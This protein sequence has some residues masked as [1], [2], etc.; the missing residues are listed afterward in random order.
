MAVGGGG[1]V[2][3]GGGGAVIAKQVFVRKG[4]IEQNGSKKACD[5][6]YR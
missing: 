5:F 2:V 6:L 3:W 1:G 4:I